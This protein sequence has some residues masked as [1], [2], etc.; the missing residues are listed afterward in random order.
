MESKVV[1]IGGGKVGLSYA[2]ALLNQKTKVSEIVLIDLDEER[3][4]G[5]VMDLNHGLSFAP[6]KIVIRAGRYEDCMNAAI[7]CICAGKSQQPG[8]SRLDLIRLNNEMIKDIVANVLRTNFHGVFLVATNPVDIIT[9]LVQKY[10]KF[11]TNKV[12]GSGTTLDTA[13][14]RYLIGDKL[15]I[16][17]KNIHAY[18]LG[19]HGD[20]EFIAWSNAFIGN[21]LIENYLG[22]EELN[23]LEEVVKRAAYDIIDRKGSTSY[24]IGMA[25]VRI[26]KAILHN[27]NTIL[28]VSSYDQINDI[29]IGLPS[30][31]N[32]HGA[33]VI[34]ELSLSFKE[35]AQLDNSISVLKEEI[36]G[37]KC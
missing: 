6:N 30:L 11:P 8:Q 7:V 5:E 35:K 20:S 15:N 16:N 28:T 2:Y 32:Q 31:V 3:I 10:S 25:L 27:E 1:I 23:K 33:F 9:Y 37:I 13:R 29:Y 4:I 24:G 17:P 18:V 22:E 21:N 26:T 34:E 14:L 19:E 36:R 12:I